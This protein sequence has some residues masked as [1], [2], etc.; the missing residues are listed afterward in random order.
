MKFIIKINEIYRY[1][2]KEENQFIYLDLNKFE[3]IDELEDWNGNKIKDISKYE[4]KSIYA[5]FLSKSRVDGLPLF[6]IDTTQI[7]RDDKM[8]NILDI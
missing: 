7:D 3:V 5:T 8:S 2:I 4:G 6:E 1:S